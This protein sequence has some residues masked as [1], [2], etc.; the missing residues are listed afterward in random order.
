MT[1]MAPVKAKGTVNIT[2][3]DL[4]K[5]LN[6]TAS[7]KNIDNN[8]AKAFSDNINY[9]LFNESN[10]NKSNFILNKIN[11]NYKKFFLLIVQK[12]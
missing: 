3:A 9:D 12:E 6:C 4:V 11:I 7:I 5:L 8:T 1:T 10:L 2:K